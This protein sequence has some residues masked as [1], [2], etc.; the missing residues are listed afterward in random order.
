MQNTFKVR[1]HI[2][3]PVHIGCDE[4]YEPTGFAVDKV[5]KKLISFDPI[6][7]INS[8]NKTDRDKFLAI[9]EKGTLESIL[10]IYK[11]LWS[12]TELPQGH[13]VDITD[14]F[15]KNYERV[16]TKLQPRQV[17]QE[18]SQFS[19]YRTSF[20]PADN[21]AYIP[22]TA[23]KGALRTGWLNHLN[24]GNRTTVRKSQELEVQLLGGRFDKDPF[25]QLKLS[26]LMPVGS[27]S[28]KICFAVSKKK[29][30]SK[31]EAKGPPQILEVIKHDS[32]AV[33][34]GL[35][36]LLPTQPGS[37]TTKLANS[38]QS[39]LANACQFFNQEM[40]TE[41][42]VLKEINLSAGLA[43]KMKQK[44]G[45]RYLKTVFPVRLGRHSG[46][47]AITI[48]GVRN[49]KIMEK[50]VNGRQQYRDSPH[51]TALRLAGNAHTATSNLLPFGWVALE[52]Q[53]IDPKA[54][55]WPERIIKEL[56]KTSIAAMSGTKVKKPEP[57]APIIVTWQTANLVWTPGNQILT[58]QNSDGVKAEVKL[59]QDKSL[60]P[61]SMHKKLFAKKDIVK[62]SVVVEQQGNAW[63]IIEVRSS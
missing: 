39:F 43:A 52:L 7:L 53:E 58:A 26:D 21:S 61:A 57:V 1:L 38:L 60:V 55:F 11:F 36:S 45:E 59:A 62:A 34:E 54:N 32:D 44:F 23:L 9:C 19:I 63:R 5:N 17:K 13:Q 16:A 30:D 24:K 56:D 14:G 20:L 40:V 49:I 42:Q 29:K 51:S 18:L 41:E 47:E 50:R 35:I 2:F 12:R 15:L 22:G 8:F 4:V 33:F 25:S 46:A 10:E 31:R 27:I 37:Q 6:S 28:T 48:A 3:S